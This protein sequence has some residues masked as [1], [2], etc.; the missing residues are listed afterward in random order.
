MNNLTLIDISEEDRNKIIDIFRDGDIF[1]L[2]QDYKENDEG[3]G[4]FV[5]QLENDTDDAFIDHSE[6]FSKIFKELKCV[7]MAFGYQNDYGD[8]NDTNIA[9]AIWFEKL[10]EDLSI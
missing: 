10:A 9:Y 4:Y 5:A 7:C 1:I 6:E 2:N 8:K 3:V